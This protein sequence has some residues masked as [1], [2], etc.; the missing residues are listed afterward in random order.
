MMIH[1][2]INVSIVK[3]TTPV[4]KHPTPLTLM[5]QPAEVLTKYSIKTIM[6]LPAYRTTM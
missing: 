2:N 1:E 6:T 5:L 3:I 4:N